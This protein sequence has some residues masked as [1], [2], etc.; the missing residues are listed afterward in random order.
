LTQT[1]GFTFWTPTEGE[2]PPWNPEGENSGVAIY[3]SRMK[4]F[5]R[6]KGQSAVAAAAYRAGECLWDE[7]RGKI[8]S[9]T[10][11]G[12][13][14]ASFILLPDG[15][16]SWMND[17][18]MLWN[19]A[20]FS[21]KRCNSTV[22]RELE[23]GL[24]SC[25]S[26]EERE[27]AVRDLCRK[28]IDRYGVAVDVAI[29]LPNRQGDERNHHAHIL[30]TTRSVIP[31][32]FGKK[33]VKLDGYR[34]GSAEVK[35]LRAEWAEILNL[36]LDRAGS[37]ERVDHRSH[38][39]RGIDAPPQI[40]EGVSAT[41]MK[42]KGLK[43]R[44]SVV[45]VDFRGR[46][47]DYIAIDQ[48]STRAQ[49]NADI[50]DLQKYRQAETEIEKLARINMMVQDTTS[51]IEQLQAAIGSS[52]LSEDII[53]LARIRLEKLMMR[54]FRKQET[55]FLRAVREI[56][57][58]RRQ[59]KEQQIYQTRLKKIQ[60]E[61]QEQFKQEQEKRESLQKLLSSAMMMPVRLNGI[62]PYTIKLQIPLRAQFNEAAY[63]QN[64]KAMNTSA[65]EKVLFRPPNKPPQRAMATL[66]LRQDVLAVKE[67][68]GR[69]KLPEKNKGQGTVLKAQFA[70]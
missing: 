55:T 4:V 39:E 37:L 67:L 54:I 12:G 16:P 65:I 34:K 52:T 66:T 18:S 45:K 22:A 40:H 60:A 6:R 13:I 43:P 33:T 11:K 35:V 2:E 56:R 42:R 62:P 58:K 63:S 68:L 46:V 29:H 3:H 30:F 47:V 25:L 36:A 24:P 31:T 41:A 17:R 8:A 70:P 32:G 1:R 19:M 51:T 20:E 69:A 5:S 15:A 38:K 49:H 48:G 26:T 64:L 57:A 50:I 10:D 53:V 61:L 9:Y 59:L 23:V 7:R 21:E 27:Q 14:G 44:E 28:L